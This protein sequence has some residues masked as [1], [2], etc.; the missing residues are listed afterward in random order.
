MFPGKAF[1]VFINDQPLNLRDP[2]GMQIFER[3]LT[4]QAVNDKVVYKNVAAK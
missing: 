4:G 2:I 1:P 3:M